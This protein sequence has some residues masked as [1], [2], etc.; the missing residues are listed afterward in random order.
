MS[1]II[2]WSPVHGQT[3]TTS[4]ILAISLLAG[5]SYHQKVL[6]TQTQFH[7]NNLEAP[8]VGSNSSHISSQ[9][10]KDFFLDVGLDAVMRNFKA[11][12]L[13]KDEIENCCIT[14]PEINL[15]LLPGTLKK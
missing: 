13:T 8:L 6:L 12:Q 15:S 2:F 14:W 1:K 3:R 7:Y 11:S 5:L 10:S 4:N 9:I